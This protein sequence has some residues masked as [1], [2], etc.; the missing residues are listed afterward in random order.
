[1]ITVLYGFEKFK[2]YKVG[3]KFW[4]GAVGWDELEVWMLEAATKVCHLLL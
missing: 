2:K 1:M 3:E 4:S